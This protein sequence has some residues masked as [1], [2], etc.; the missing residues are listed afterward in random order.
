MANAAIVEQIKAHLLDLRT[1]LTNAWRD[2]EPLG[3]VIIGLAEAYSALAKLTEN[4]QVKGCKSSAATLRSVAA[5]LLV[6]GIELQRTEQLAATTTLVPTPE[7]TE[8]PAEPAKTLTKEPVA[9]GSEWLTNLG[10]IAE[11]IPN[12]VPPWV[13]AERSPL[14]EEQPAAVAVLEKG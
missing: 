6:L 5:E 3:D 13:L 2:Q 7:P 10:A 14:A 9:P 12:A 11:R 1:D 8:P 4:S